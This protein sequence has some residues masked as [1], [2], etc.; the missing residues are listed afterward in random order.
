M[1]VGKHCC[2]SWPSSLA[3]CSEDPLALLAKELSRRGHQPLV[4]FARLVTKASARLST[5]PFSRLNLT[6]Y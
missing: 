3:P 1:P 6:V 2:S 4:K 5:M